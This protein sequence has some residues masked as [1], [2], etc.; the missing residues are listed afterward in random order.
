MLTSQDSMNRLQSIISDSCGSKLVRVCRANSQPVFEGAPITRHH[1]V[2]VKNGPESAWLECKGA[3]T[4]QYRPHSPLMWGEL[5]AKLGNEIDL[6]SAKIQCLWYGTGERF[7]IS[8]FADKL[9]LPDDNIRDMIDLRGDYGGSAAVRCTMGAEIWRC[10][11]GLVMMSGKLAAS[12]SRKHTKHFHHDID[13]LLRK[14]VKTI[15]G[16]NR[17]RETFQRMAETK[18]PDFRAKIDQILGISGSDISTQL[19]NRR[20]AIISRLLRESEHQTD[21][22]TAWRVA[23]AVHGHFQWDQSRAVTQRHGA[24]MDDWASNRAESIRAFEL[25]A[26][27]SA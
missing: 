3:V 4:S 18:V 24:H 13:I 1:S 25:M 21:R 11:N 9:D 15:A 5:I 17:Q 8:G 20:T 7:K 10:S 26:E 22:I 12:V 27:L 14:F 6:N 23:N 2:Y 16:Y 19:Q